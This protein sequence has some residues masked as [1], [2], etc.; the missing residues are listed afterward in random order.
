MILTADGKRGQVVGDRDGKKFQFYV[1]TSVNSIKNNEFASN[2]SLND[3][4]T[5]G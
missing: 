4:N 3:Q 5:S 1:I 2:L